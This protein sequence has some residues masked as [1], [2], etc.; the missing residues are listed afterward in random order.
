MSW[1]K[2]NENESIRSITNRRSGNASRGTQRNDKSEMDQAGMA[3]TGMSAPHGLV[4][5]ELLLVKCRIALHDHSFLGQLLH[6]GEQAA[7]VGLERLGD[8][9]I[10]AQH[11]VG[12]FE[13]L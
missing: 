13:M 9:R 3:R 5:V 2:E 10:H 12:V 6:F 7:V 1:K 4:D 11:H 8:F